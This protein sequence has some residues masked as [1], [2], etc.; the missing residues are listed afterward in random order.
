MQKLCTKYFMK[1]E[2]E[3]IENTLKEF[4]VLNEYYFFCF[5]L[6]KGCQSD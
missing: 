2:K 6:C 3:N 4:E 1:K 5:A